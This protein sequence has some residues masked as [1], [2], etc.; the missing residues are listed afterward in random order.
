[1]FD[2]GRQVTPMKWKVSVDERAGLPVWIREIEDV[3]LSVYRACDTHR[4]WKWE[5]RYGIVTVTGYS[6][7]I[8]AAKMRA[9]RVAK[10]YALQ[11]VLH[12]F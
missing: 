9:T 12:G 10:E 11:G 4:Q 3:H 5:V 7:T 6:K 1:M 2:Q 8:R